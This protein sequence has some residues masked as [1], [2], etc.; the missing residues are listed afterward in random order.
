MA[1]SKIYIFST[2][3]LELINA[4]RQIDLNNEYRRHH[5]IFKM[6]GNFVK[7][8]WVMCSSKLLIKSSVQLYIICYANIKMLV[9]IRF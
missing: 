3:Y 1:L 2:Q 4:T 7:K 8:I 6:L 9:I 5:I